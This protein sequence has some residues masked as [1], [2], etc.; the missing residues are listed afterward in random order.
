MKDGE[1]DLVEFSEMVDEFLNEGFNYFDTAHGYLEGKSEVA[2]RHA[3][4]D[5][6]PRERYLLADK[7]TVPYFQSAEDIRPFFEKQLE[8]CGVD[9]FDF[10][11]MHA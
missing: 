1:V 8:I 7:L 6:Y 5:R 3:L 4:V 11:L 9:Y 2:L 10:Y